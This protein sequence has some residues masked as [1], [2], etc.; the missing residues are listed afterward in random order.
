M[1][2]QHSL[3]EELISMMAFDFKGLKLLVGAIR[4]STW[5]FPFK[6]FCVVIA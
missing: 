4:T 5:E 6:V 2:S 3:S 1:M